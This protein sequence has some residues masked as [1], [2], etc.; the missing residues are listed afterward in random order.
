MSSTLPT[1]VIANWKMNPTTSTTVSE[2]LQQLA[3]TIQQQNYQSN[4]VLIPSFIHLNQVAEF[5]QQNNVNIGLSA[6]NMCAY[7]GDNGAFTG[8]ISAQMLKN[9]GANYVII[10]HSERRQYFDENDEIL[11][12]KITH[13][14]SHDLKVIF[15]IGE[16]LQQYQ[17]QETLQIL[18]NQLAILVN[19]QQ[20]LANNNPQN[21]ILLVAYEP[22]WAIGTGLT[23]TVEEITNVHQFI[24]QTL[25]NM[26]LDAPILYGGSVNANNA[27]EIA[28]ISGVDG[29]LVGGASLVSE[30]FC[31]IID[32]FDKK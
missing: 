3:T 28:N 7:R 22:V 13:A 11:S 15:C 8:E 27:Q 5:I 19:F 21:P 16:T 10:G 29:A 9:I 12:Q 25:S 14:L 30:S 4:V 32:A 23:P 17:N 31:Q 24:R 18:K 6:Q 2:L 26:Q 20:Q 1:W